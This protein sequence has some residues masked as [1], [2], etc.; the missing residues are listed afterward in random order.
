MLTKDFRTVGIIREISSVGC[1]CCFRAGLA[2]STN[3]VEP[4]TNHP[5][6][7]TAQLS[8]RTRFSEIERLSSV[9]AEEAGH[10]V[11]DPVVLAEIKTLS[12]RYVA[13]N[14][15][16][17]LAAERR[18]GASRSDIASAAWEWCGDSRLR[19]SQALARGRGPWRYLS[20]P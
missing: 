15:L 2:F 1:P 5:E 3:L 9:I 11:H 17:Y 12:R 13:R 7:Q 18:A 19:G 20:Y 10:R 8:R 6:S 4:S 14:F 16:G